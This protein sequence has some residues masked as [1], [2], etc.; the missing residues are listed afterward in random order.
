M[1][2]LWP[3]HVPIEQSF[4]QFTANKKLVNYQSRVSEFVPGSEFS[5]LT[6]L[7]SPE[8]DGTNLSAGNFWGAE[9]YISSG[10]MQRIR[11]SWRGFATSWHK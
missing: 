4:Q 5:Q 6:P 9:K 3:E 7:V 11:N 8:L 2:L 1:T 10:I